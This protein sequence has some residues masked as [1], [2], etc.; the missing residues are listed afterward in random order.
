MKIMIMTDMEC[1]S[2]LTC[3]EY[4]EGPRPLWEDARAS[5]TGDINAAA[6]GC[7]QGGAKEV[8]IRL[9]HGPDTVLL[10]KLDERIT[11][12]GEKHNN[13]SGLDE[14]YDATLMVGQHAKAGTMDA[15]L[16]HTQATGAIFVLIRESVE[17]R[18]QGGPEVLL[19]LVRVIGVGVIKTD[20]VTHLRENEYP[21]VEIGPNGVVVEIDPVD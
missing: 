19:T 5:L 8:A 18:I 21:V 4:I 13:F 1:V 9:G 7:F 3:A 16:E 14:S 15:F 17:M 10:D 2:G 12:T 11:I 20:G 6:E